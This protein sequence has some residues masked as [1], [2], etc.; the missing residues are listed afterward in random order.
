MTFCSPSNKQFENADLNGSG[1]SFSQT[2]QL[3]MYELGANCT[4]TR[5]DHVGKVLQPSENLLPKSL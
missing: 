5:N 1:D 4:T 2:K 3:V